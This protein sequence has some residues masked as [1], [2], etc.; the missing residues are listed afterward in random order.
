MKLTPRDK[1]KVVFLCNQPYR[2]IADGLAFSTYSRSFPTAL[3]NIFKEVLRTTGTSTYPGDGDLST[4]AK[5]G[6]LLMNWDLLIETKQS[7]SSVCITWDLLSGEILR[8]LYKDDPDIIFVPFGTEMAS[9]LRTYVPEAK[10]VIEAP[11]ADATDFVGS[12]IFTKIQ[13]RLA[14]L[15]KGKIYWTSVVKNRIGSL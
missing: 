10:Q 2:K 1:V 15:G 7:S 8:T 3:S 6:V 4:W 12:S 14:D 11:Y 5:Q 9:R 13:T